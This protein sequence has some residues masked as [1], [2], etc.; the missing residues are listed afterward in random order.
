MVA[1]GCRVRIVYS[2]SLSVVSKS[3]ICMK[4]YLLSTMSL[5]EITFNVFGE[6]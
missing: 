6:F 4:L 2:I 3:V 1:C 5:S